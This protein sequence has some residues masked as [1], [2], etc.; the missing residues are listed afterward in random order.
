MVKSKTKTLENIE[1]NLITLAFFGYTSA[2][3]TSFINAILSE[4]WKKNKKI[5]YAKKRWKYKLD[6]NYDVFPKA[7]HL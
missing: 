3:K 4:I 7:K 5:L 1:K 2:G 6:F